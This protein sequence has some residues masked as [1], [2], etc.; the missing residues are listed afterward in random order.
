MLSRLQVLFFIT[1]SF[2]LAVGILLIIL[3]CAVEGVWWTMV[4]ALFCAFLPLPN[5]LAQKWTSMQDATT[6][7]AFQ[8][9][10]QRS[11]WLNARILEAGYFLTALMIVISMALPLLFFHAA[12]ISQQSAILAFFGALTMDTAILLYGKYFHHDQD[13]AFY[14]M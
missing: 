12:Y 10:S 2:L 3:S 9:S 1:L 7:V 13:E 5:K 6:A 11:D 4:V 14:F 8:V